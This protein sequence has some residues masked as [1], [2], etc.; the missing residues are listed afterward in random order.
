MHVLLFRLLCLALFIKKWLPSWPHHTKFALTTSI[1]RIWK[2]QTLMKHWKL[3]TTQVLLNFYWRGKNKF[4]TLTLQRCWGVARGGRAAAVHF[5]QVESVMMATVVFILHVLIITVHLRSHIHHFKLYLSSLKETARMSTFRRTEE[6]CGVLCSCV[7]A[8]V[9][10]WDKIVTASLCL[11]S[12]RLML[13]TARMA[14]P[15]CRP[16]HLSA[17]WLGW[18]SEIRMG[19]PCS[20]PPWWEHTRVN[21]THL[22]KYFF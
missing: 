9:T 13:L 5:I 21:D 17:G 15:T 20:F 14:S 6:R 10:C 22:A 7:Q 16:P 1:G 18:I 3:E 19:T 2:T 12:R 4:W 11:A 8:C